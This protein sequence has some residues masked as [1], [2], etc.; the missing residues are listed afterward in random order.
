MSSEST[1]R[2]R[3]FI[4]FAALAV[5]GAILAAVLVPMAAQASPTEFSGVVLTPAGSPASGVT[6]QVAH[7]AQVGFDAPLSA[8]TN[9]SGAFSFADVAP[10]EYSMH[11]SATATSY[12]QYLYG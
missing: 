12:A 10:G 1:R 7:K 8:K 9:S 4:P 6:V 2:V 3:R 11:F 5:T